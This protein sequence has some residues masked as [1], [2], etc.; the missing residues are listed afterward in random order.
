MSDSGIAGATSRTRSGMPPFPF[1]W[2]TRETKRF[3]EPNVLVSLAPRRDPVLQSSATRRTPSSGLGAAGE[4]PVAGTSIEGVAT[5]SAVRRVLRL[6]SEPPDTSGAVGDTQYVQWVNGGFA[7]LIRHGRGSLVE[8]PEQLWATG[9]NCARTMTAI[10][11]CS[12]IRLLVAGCW[13]SSLLVMGL[14]MASRNACVSTTSDAGVPITFMNHV[15]V[16]GRLSKIGVWPDGYYVTS[17]CTRQD[18]LIGPR[19]ALMNA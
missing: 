1:S 8:F 11:W 5:G 17:T 6:N 18:R 19:G 13:P 16:D 2:R 3:P 7:V 15:C 14:A 9:G 12:S 4:I 10:R